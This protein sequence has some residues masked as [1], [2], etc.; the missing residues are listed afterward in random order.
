MKIDKELAQQVF[1]EC[2]GIDQ[3]YITFKAFVESLQNN[4]NASIIESIV[5]GIEAIIEGVFLSQMRNNSTDKDL[6]L[7]D[8]DIRTKFKKFND[9]KALP[10]DKKTIT[11]REI[12]RIIFNKLIFAVD[13]RCPDIKQAEKL[14]SKCIEKLPEHMPKLLDFFNEPAGYSFEN[15]LNKLVINNGSTFSGY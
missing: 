1:L 11:E 7:S 3:K 12:Q 8:N 2:Y 14:Y 9:E 15:Q 5:E 13:K 10:D 4:T 6:K